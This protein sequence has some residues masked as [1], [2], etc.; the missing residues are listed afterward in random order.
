MMTFSF[1]VWLKVSLT[2]CPH[3]VSLNK[4][5][6]RQASLSASQWFSRLGI[7]EP[8]FKNVGSK[9]VYRPS[10]FYHS[11]VIFRGIVLA[12]AGKGSRGRC[13]WHTPPPDLLRINTFEARY[14]PAFLPWPAPLTNFTSV[15]GWAWTTPWECRWVCHRNATPP[16]TQSKTFTLIK[17]DLGTYYFFIPLNHLLHSF[18]VQ[19]VGHKDSDVISIHRDLYPETACK[20]DST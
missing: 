4:N 19:S 5:W 6:P 9:P 15:R 8:H 3:T 11:K 10:A 18:Y 2:F 14:P 1:E 20:G 13:T 12:P 7:P 16:S 17:I